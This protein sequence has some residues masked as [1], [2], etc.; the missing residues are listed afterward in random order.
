MSIDFD[1]ICTDAVAWLPT[2]DQA[3]ADA[4][5]AAVLDRIIAVLRADPRVP[6]LTWEAWRLLFADVEVRSRDELGELIEGKGDI[7]TAVGEI[8]DAFTARLLV[9]KARRQDVKEPTP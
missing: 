3:D 1:E 5:I 6:Q 9:I 8:V 4:V 7:D 2:L